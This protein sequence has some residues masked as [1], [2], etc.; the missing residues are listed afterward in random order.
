MKK[1]YM[2]IIS[3]VLMILL[4]LV[5]ILLKGDKPSDK[6]ISEDSNILVED[7]EQVENQENEELTKEQINEKELEKIEEPEEKQEDLDE[8]KLTKKDPEYWIDKTASKNVLLM[9]ESEINHFNNENFSRED[10]LRDIKIHESIIAGSDLNEL[11]SSFSQKP[12]GTRYDSN[13]KI[14]NQ[15]YFNKLHSNL[16]LESIEE[17]NS[18]RYGVIVNRTLM[19]KF[20]T[21]E[22]AYKKQED[23]EFDSFAETAIYPWEPVVV[24]S[25][26]KDGLWYLC[27]M[28]NYMGWVYGDDLAIGEKDDIFGKIDN[29]EFLMVVD[30]QISIEDVLF[31][32]GTK[33]PL[34]D[35]SKDRYNLLLPQKD[36]MG[37]LKFE[38]SEVKKSDSFHRGYLAYTKENIIKQGFKFINE[39][40]GWGGMNNSRDCSAL[41]MDIHRTFGIKLPRNASQQESKSIGKNYSMD[42]IENLPPASVLYMPGHTMLYLGKDDEHYMLHQYQGHYEITGDGLNYINMMKTD[43]SPMTIKNSQGKTYMDL[44][45]IAKE[46]IE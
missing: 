16:N 27:S 7:K 37:R 6:I 34:K 18:I 26:S 31:D 3:T 43:I 41:I 30:R 40:Y 39:P 24:Y 5:L 19:R 14:M 20:P 46:F 1:Q 2:L 36:D 8:K 13:G 9:N 38:E 28:Y 17:S 45:T 4:S 12:E 10:F 21:N 29:E 32:M 22:P 33:I 42:S 23:I 25:E 15:E 35:E 11:I 44:I